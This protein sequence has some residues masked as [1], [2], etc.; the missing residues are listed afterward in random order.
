MNLQ[1]RIDSL[2]AQLD[3]VKA[4]LAKPEAVAKMMRFV[5]GDKTTGDW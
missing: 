2:Q 3:A 4:E 1:E 5:N